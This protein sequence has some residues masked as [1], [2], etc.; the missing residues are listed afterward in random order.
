MLGKVAV[1]TDPAMLEV[2]NLEHSSPSITS[3][4]VLA[5]GAVCTGLRLQPSHTNYIMNYI[6]SLQH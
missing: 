6:M 2:T 4:I 3:D 1:Y 5:L